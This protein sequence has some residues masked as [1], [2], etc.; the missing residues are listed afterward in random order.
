MSARVNFAWSVLLSCFLMLVPTVSMCEEGYLI[1]NCWASLSGL[2]G[3]AW[4]DPVPI[5]TASASGTTPTH[6]Q[7]MRFDDQQS[8]M[9][10]CQFICPGDYDATS[11][12]PPSIEIRGWAE[13]CVACTESTFKKVRFEVSSYGCDPGASLN[14]SYSTTTTGDISFECLNNACSGIDGT[15]SEHLSNIQIDATTD[16]GLWGFGD[17]VYI[18]IKRDGAVSDDLA[19]DFHVSG[20]IVRY[21][22]P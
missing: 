20:V 12:N 11:G 19:A 17:M 18:K 22:K 9:M 7:G 21:D 3:L 13:S 15:R 6:S 1:P 2:D 4:A 8:E 5:D 14:G 16:S 10:I